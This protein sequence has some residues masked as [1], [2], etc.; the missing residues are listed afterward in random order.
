MFN[1]TV[2]SQNIFK[3]LLLIGWVTTWLAV[4]VAP[5]AIA[6]TVDDNLMYKVPDTDK[7]DSSIHTSVWDNLSN[8]T[9][10]S[11][12]HHIFRVP[13]LGVGIQ[14]YQQIADG[15]GLNL[16]TSRSTAS[17]ISASYLY[18]L[19][20]KFRIGPELM[21]SMY[22]NSGMIE[23]KNSLSLMLRAEYVFFERNNLQMYGLA[24]TGL[25]FNA[26]DLVYVRYL[27]SKESSDLSY[28]NYILRPVING[29]ILPNSSP[30]FY[31]TT[32]PNFTHLNWDIVK[33]DNGKTEEK[34]Q[35]RGNGFGI[36]IYNNTDDNSTIVM[37]YSPYHIP[38]SAVSIPWFIGVGLDYDLSDWFAKMMQLNSID[39]QISS[40]RRVGISFATRYFDNGS[41]RLT[42]LSIDP[43]LT[44][45]DNI[46]YSPDE[47]NINF[48][49][50]ISFSF[51]LYFK[52]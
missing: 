16:T 48:K 38:K 14:T 29:A 23:L 28:K 39:N 51:S 47:Y 15:K 18:G 7:A 6:F 24:G 1:L 40:K 17:S 11:Y 21:H 41:I 33:D 26:V 36:C 42:E 25:S 19:S 13:A 30:Y 37:K 9:K 44:T 43:E 10:H 50:Y 45:K 5:K 2:F 20:P 34:S 8:T 32:F 3:N 35:A 46:Y 49:G 12:Q 4:G 22:N 52:M 27:P 31:C